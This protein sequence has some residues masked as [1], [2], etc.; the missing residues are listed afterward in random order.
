MVKN[1]V[2]SHN[3]SEPT[4]NNIAGPDI[5]LIRRVWLKAAQA[6]TQLNLLKQLTN[7]KIGL[8][9]VEDY[10]ADLAEKKKS[11]KMKNRNLRDVALI[12]DIMNKKVVDADQAR[13]EFDFEKVKLR[14]NIDDS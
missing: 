8:N 6:E 10:V 3:D 9:E 14:R 2:T 1:N 7:L 13:R 4:A 11:M 5:S 12:V